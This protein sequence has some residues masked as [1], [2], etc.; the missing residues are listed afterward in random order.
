MLYG[1][2]GRP[3]RYAVSIIA[4]DPKRLASGT[5]QNHFDHYMRRIHGANLPAFTSN[6]YVESRRAFFAGLWFYRNYVLEMADSPELSDPKSCVPTRLAD[7]IN[8]KREKEIQGFVAG[9]GEN[10]R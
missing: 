3:G 6:Q 10:Y 5:I 1:P 7:M 9:L 8:D 2:F 4:F